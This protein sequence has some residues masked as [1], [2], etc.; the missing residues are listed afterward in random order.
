[1]KVI[2]FNLRNYHLNGDNLF[3]TGVE[4]GKKKMIA[5]ELSYLLDADSL[6]VRDADNNQLMVKG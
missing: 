4:F 1:M 2:T 3:F 6:Y 5:R